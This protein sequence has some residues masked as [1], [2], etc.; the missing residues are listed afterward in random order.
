[1][2][3]QY[4]GKGK[5][6]PAKNSRHGAFNRALLKSKG[7]GVPDVNPTYTVTGE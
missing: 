2:G 4:V 5:E 3:P 7:Y 6:N 1:M